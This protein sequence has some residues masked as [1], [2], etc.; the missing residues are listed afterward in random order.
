LIFRAVK[1]SEDG[2]RRIIETASLN[3][4]EGKEI[5]VLSRK[6]SCRTSSRQFTLAD[7]I[8]FHVVL[9]SRG[10]RERK[11]LAWTHVL[12]QADSIIVALPV[13]IT[14]FINDT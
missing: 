5:S 7:A 1:V 6:R 14:R 12:Q 8:V 10:F 4:R 2:G 11:D 13:R 9:L 3:T